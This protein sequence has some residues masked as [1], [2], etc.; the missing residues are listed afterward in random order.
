VLRF[1]VQRPGRDGLLELNIQPVREAHRDYP[2]IGIVPG[3]GLEIGAFLA[4]AG[5]ADPPE[6][7]GFGAGKAESFLDTLAAAGP[8]D[9][10][11]TP[12]SS[13]DQYR[14]L[15]ARERARPIRHLIERRAASAGEE[16]PVLERFELTVPPVHFV[17]F[18]LVLAAE[19]IRAIQADSP[20]EKAGFRP[21]D[22]IVKVDGDDAIDPMSLPGRCFDGAGRP[23]T[24]QIERATAAGPEIQTLT[25]TPDD[26][27]P[28]TE[29]ILENEDLDI[30]G[31]GLCLPVTTHVAGVRRGSPA[32][33]AGLKPG[34]VINSLTVK[35]HL[36]QRVGPAKDQAKGRR[37]RPAADRSTT[38]EF[39]DRSTSWVYAF[40]TLQDLPLSEVEL[41]VNKSSEPRRI[42]PEPD[43]SW[44]YPLRG[45]RFLGLIRRLPPQPIAA[46]LWRGYD[47]TIENILNIYAT[48]RS[49]AT[50]RVSASSMGGVITISTVAYDAARL[51]LTHLIHFLGILSINLAVLNFLPIPP[52]DGGQMVFLLAEKVR[53]RPLPESALIAGTYLGL[54]FVLGLM[55][56]VTYQDIYRL[57]K[58]YF[59]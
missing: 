46:A 39:D 55:V 37:G 19:P 53:G 27:P 54:F 7:P 51:G 22:R 3:A 41:V 40:K 5:L 50:R 18:G 29:P 34:D 2:T 44:D 10:P 33:R 57:V 21:G 56:F 32:A 42:A 49:L 48:F 35:P 20:A 15:L 38:F 36:P 47:D 30:P 26:T 6:F 45:L 24:F 23:M 16:G 52:L 25:A 9:R 28:W 11:P 58:S 17:D 4:P 8:A 13:V 31:L 59:W 43:P 14:R 1:G 12:L